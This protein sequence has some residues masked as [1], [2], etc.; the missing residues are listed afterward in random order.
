MSWND[1]NY[2][3][4]APF[5]VNNHSAQTAASDILITVPGDWPEFWDNVLESG[6][7]IRVTRQDGIT[8]ETFGLGSFNKANRVAT[9]QIQD[10]SLV[11]L[12][13][14]AAV[15]AV[16]GWIYWGYPNADSSGQ[17]A[18]TPNSPMT[19]TI[20]VGT[21]GSGS[22]RVVTC[23]PEAPGSTT[24]RT[25]IGKMAGEEIHLWWDPSGVLATRRT[26]YQNSRAF[27]EI[28]NVTYRVDD[29]GNPQSGMID[30]DVRIAGPAY[31]RTVLKAGSSGSIYVAVL[32]V[33]LTEGRK[34]EFRCTVRVQDPVE[35]S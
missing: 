23:R 5:T 35:P 18:F 4:R 16:S 13:S 15:A 2:A 14:A 28:H 27:E 12:D 29:G 8:A 6:N 7:D 30:S 34:L 3:Y 17:T 1:S 32:L 10:K 22:Q 33:E 25:E 19:G 24:P 21:P 31:V 11:D 20:V 26:P 9:I